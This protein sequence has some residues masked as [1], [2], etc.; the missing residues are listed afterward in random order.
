VEFLILWRQIL[1]KRVALGDYRC[2]S[3]FIGG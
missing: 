2:S 3:A 1:R